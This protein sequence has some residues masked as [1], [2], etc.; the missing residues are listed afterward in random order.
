[1]LHAQSKVLLHS[2][3]RISVQYAVLFVDP[4]SRKVDVSVKIKTDTKNNNEIC[5]KT[6]S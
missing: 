5:Q 2:H 4:E 3:D 6:D 1:M